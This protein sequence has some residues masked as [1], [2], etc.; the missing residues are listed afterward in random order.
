MALH[1]GLPLRALLDHPAEP[2]GGTIT[3]SAG[4]GPSHAV[5]GWLDAEM[6]KDIRAGGDNWKADVFSLLWILC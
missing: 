1:V 6:G 2:G 4:H 5:F 3:S